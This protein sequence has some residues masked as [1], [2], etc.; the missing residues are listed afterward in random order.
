MQI[1]PRSTFYVIWS[2]VQ[3]IFLLFIAISVPLRLA[4]DPKDACELPIGWTY[5]DL[6]VDTVF[7]ADLLLNFF[8]CRE[9]DSLLVDVWSEVAGHYIK[10]YETA[11][12]NFNL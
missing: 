4:F 12:T 2:S 3:C 9:I 1:H 11:F 7:V 8:V 10:Q 5:W 6:I